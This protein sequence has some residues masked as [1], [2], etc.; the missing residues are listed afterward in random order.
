MHQAL[1][2]QDEIQTCSAWSSHNN[3]SCF[4]IALSHKITENTA[5]PCISV[6]SKEC[7]CEGA[8]NFMK[9]ESKRKQLRKQKKLIKAKFS[10]NKKQPSETKQSSHTCQSSKHL[11]KKSSHAFKNSSSFKSSSLKS[12][13]SSQKFNRKIGKLEKNNPALFNL[14]QS[15]NLIKN[16]LNNPLGNQKLDQ[17]FI[18]DGLDYLLV[19]GR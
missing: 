1:P 10:A 2:E 14:L 15:Q 12:S 5:I 13:S 7:V 6:R 16:N 19:Y 18:N 3:Y 8:K 11:T 17:E 4:C 9:F